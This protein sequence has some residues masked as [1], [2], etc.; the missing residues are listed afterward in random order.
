MTSSVQLRRVDLRS[1]SGMEQ[2]EAVRRQM[3]PRGEVLSQAARQKTIQLFGAPLSPW[4]SVQRICEDVRQRGFEALAHYARVL[5]GEP[6][7]PDRLRVDPQ[8]MEQAHRQ[9]DPQFLETV[10]W[11]RDNIRQFQ[12]ALIPR[13]SVVQR[14]GVQLRH[15]Y[16]PLR[17]V[18]LCVPGGAAAYP[19]TL[20]MTAVPAQ[21]AGVPEVAVMAPPTPFGA[22]N[23]YVRAVCHELGIRELYRLGGAHGV[24]ALAYGV[25]GVAPV[26]KIA[27][28]GNLFV[29]LAKRH[30]FGQVGIDTVAGP[31][32]VVVVV[33][34]STPPDLAAADLLAQAEHAPGASLCVSWDEES[35]EQVLQA[36]Q[37]RLEGL[38]R[39][40]ATRHSLEHYGAMILCRDREQACQVIDHIAPEHLH[41]D[42]EDPEPLLERVRCAGAVFL[43]IHTPVALGDYVAGPSHVLP[44]GGA[45]RWS[46]GLSALDFLR[47]FSIL[48]YQPE[49]L[50]EAAPHVQRLALAE[51]LDAHWQSVAC[52]LER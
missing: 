10:R 26:E 50:A 52:R 34:R 5:D 3:S 2:L 15:R 47:S 49:G 4:E 16:V 9:C 20:L 13:E 22:D 7:T 43:G 23:P 28:P 17:R 35:L 27:G 37:H 48:Q 36:L 42:V 51:G 6:L 18:G 21:A 44:T 45:A 1:P 33:D 25:E 14:P 32:E 39:Q 41:L 46:S 24:A 11:V 29:A 19:S 12:E 8:A 30:V 38:G 40:E 31:S